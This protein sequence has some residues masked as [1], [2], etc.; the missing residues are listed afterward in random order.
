M[1]MRFW[2]PVAAPR[3]R[4][5]GLQCSCIISSKLLDSGLTALHLALLG[6]E[7]SGEAEGSPLLGQGVV[8]SSGRATRAPWGRGKYLL[9]GWIMH[10]ASLDRDVAQQRKRLFRP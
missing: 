4:A 7:L 9:G 3:S 8:S 2:H 1:G 6:S 10:W 5:L